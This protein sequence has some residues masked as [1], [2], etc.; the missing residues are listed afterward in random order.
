[1]TPKR[2]G[3]IR[4]STISDDGIVSSCIKHDTADAAAPKHDWCYSENRTPPPSKSY[5]YIYI[6]YIFFIFYI[7]FFTNYIYV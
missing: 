5:I 7:F 4:F 3:K 2:R 6:L 1:M